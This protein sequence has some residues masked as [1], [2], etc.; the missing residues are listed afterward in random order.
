MRSVFLGGVCLLLLLVCS[1]GAQNSEQ[2]PSTGSQSNTS[3]S[4]DKSGMQ[5]SQGAAAQTQTA[6]TSG[7]GSNESLA[8][9][10]VIGAELTKSIDAKKAKSGDQFTAR[11]LNDVR[12]ES[13]VVI[14]RGSKLMGHVTEAKP[15]A[16]GESDS[17]LGIAFDKI[18]VKNGQE[19]P[20]HAAIQ[21]VARPQRAPAME[22][23]S[24]SGSGGG[25]SNPSGYGGM[26]PGGRSCGGKA[27][28]WR[29]GSR[30]MAMTTT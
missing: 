3:V 27:R 26:G 13:G 21:A 7:T 19:I 14:L 2:S 16:K 1:A 28:S 9:G 10:T 8:A 11:V 20:V 23:G 29:S 18:E 24:A 5:T 25:Y 4:S 30:W 22:S 12:S 17:V 6:P 15:R